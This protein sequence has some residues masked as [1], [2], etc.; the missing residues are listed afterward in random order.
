M[1][2]LYFNW[3]EFFL[4]QD[5]SCYGMVFKDAPVSMDRAVYFL[6]PPGF[7]FDVSVHVRNLSILSK[8]MDHSAIAA[9]GHTN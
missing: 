4:L 9:A 2:G 5:G 1:A 6:N 7:P 3:S 8:M